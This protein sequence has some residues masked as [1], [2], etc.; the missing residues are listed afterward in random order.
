MHLIQILLP[1]QDDGGR[2]FPADQYEGLLRELTQIFGG[3]TSYMRSPAEG[4]WHQGGVTEHDE[5][6]VIE[7]MAAEL[8]RG[9]WT[10]LRRR[11]MHEFR[12]DEVVIRAQRIERL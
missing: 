8:D 2:A 12:Q 7:I 1:V 3:A 6:V 9:W 10:A 5:I 11:L 4:R